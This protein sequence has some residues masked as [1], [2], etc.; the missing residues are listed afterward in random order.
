MK[1]NIQFIELRK[2][3]KMNNVLE[4]L[5][6]SAPYLAKCRYLGKILRQYCPSPLQEKK[7]VIL[8]LLHGLPLLLGLNSLLLFCFHSIRPHTAL[9]SLEILIVAVSRSQ[10]DPTFGKIPLDE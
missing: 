4:E 10:S 8:L 6:D 3:F 7:S 2:L 9:V 1:R 5:K